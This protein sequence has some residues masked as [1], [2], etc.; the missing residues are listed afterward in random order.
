MQVLKNIIQDNIFQGYAYSYPHKS[1]YRPL[2]NPKQLK[3]LW[4]EENKNSLFLY[5]HIPFC[6]MRCG[7][8]NLFTYANPK[9]DLESPFVQ[10]LKR[11]TETVKAAIGQAKFA[12]LAIGGGTPTFLSL[13]DLETVFQLINQVMAANSQVIPTSVEMSPKTALP[14]KLALL[15]QYGTTRASI[16]VQ[17]FLLAETKAL[18]RPQKTEEVVKALTAIKASGIPEMNIDLIYG[19]AGQTLESWQYSLERTLEFEPE[20]IFLYPLYVRPLTGLGVKDKEWDDHRKRLYR[21]GRDF[22]L[23]DGYE[24][25]SMRLFRKKSAKITEGPAYHSSEDGMIG[26][27]VGARSYTKNFH[28][29]SD[30]AVGRKGVKQIIHDYNQWTDQQFAQANY[31]IN[32]N[33]DE[34]KRRY[35]IKSLLEGS[36]LDLN[37]YTQYFGS[38]AMNDYPQ[39]EELYTLNLVNTAFQDRIQLNYD[40]FELSDVLGPW[41]YSLAVKEKMQAFELI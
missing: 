12:R 11:Q 1:A 35:I 8:C 21:A 39:L 2:E 15:A 29:S 7:F 25:H 41:L 31:G 18:G 23:T 10:A 33:L 3:D 22:L 6:E 36:Y 5:L 37:R 9:S 38:M 4:A 20:E 32:L 27:G 13:K 24:Q 28:Y 19:A 16:G 17:S 34:Q 30:Y 14:E 26:L 40:G